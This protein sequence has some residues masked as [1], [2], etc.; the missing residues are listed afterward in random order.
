LYA[1]Y[2]LTRVAIDVQVAEARERG[3]G[4]LAL[5][6]AVHVDIELA[7]NQVVATLP[8]LEL[9]FSYLYAT[10]HYLVT[11]A[12]LAWIFV[13]RRAQYALARNAPRPSYG[14]EPAPRGLSPSHLI[15]RSSRRATE[16]W[17][18]CRRARTRCLSSCPHWRRWPRSPDRTCSLQVGRY[19]VGY[20]T[21][22]EPMV[23]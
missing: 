6:Q 16:A 4:I 9:A 11:P 8:A 13:R 17:S 12:V 2:A 3:L 10:L 14:V 22:T 18:N 5:E 20:L 15:S 21:A 7:M 19:V 23:E 1:A